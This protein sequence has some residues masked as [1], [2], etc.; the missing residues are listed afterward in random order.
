MQ[1]QFV[2]KRGSNVLRGQV[3]DQFR[4]DKLNANTWVNVARGIP[5]TKLKQHEYGANIGGP[6]IK[7]RLF[8]FAN[9]EQNYPPGEN[10][11][12]RGV[13]TSEAQQGIF[14]YVAADGTERTAKLLTLPPRTTS[15]ARSI[16]TSPR[17]CRS[18][19]ARS[20]RGTSVADTLFRNTTV[21]STPTRPTRTSIRRRVSTIS[22]RRRWPFAACS[23]CTGATCPTRPQFPALPEV[24]DG[25]TSRTTSSPPA[26]TGRS[27]RIC[28]TRSVSACRATSR[29]SGRAT[30]W[31]FTLRRAAAASRSRSASPRRRSP[32]TRCPSP[33]T[34]R[35][36]T[37]RTPS[38]GCA[39]RT[40]SASA[41]RSGERRCTSR[42]A[43]RRTRYT[44][45]SRPATRSRGSSARRRCRASATRTSPT[46]GTCMR[47]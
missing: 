9:F 37:S 19:T 44:S 42:S 30:R 33:A 36:T 45:A 2:T 41:A 3:F 12:T 13:L 18:S 31:R 20:S 21:S 26:P 32:A 4:S 23:T 40:R 22:I 10:T 39:G 1:I 6:I 17:S 25:F 16:R 11:Q 15:R 47:C 7:G 29:S 46:S 8:F 34:T 5:K 28:S 27:V 14:R 43:A 24:S 35:S 38:P